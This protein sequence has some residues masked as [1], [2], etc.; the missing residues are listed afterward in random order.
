MWIDS[1][2]AVSSFSKDCTSDPKYFN[3]IKLQS[4]DQDKSKEVFDKQTDALRYVDWG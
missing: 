4:I 1:T 2:F 3:H